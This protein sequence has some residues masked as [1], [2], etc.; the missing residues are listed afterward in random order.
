MKIFFISRTPNLIATGKYLHEIGNFVLGLNL[1]LFVILVEN[2]L[3]IY[4]DQNLM[5]S[6]FKIEYYLDHSY[7][8]LICILK[9]SI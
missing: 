8:G 3:C 5:I 2:Y 4:I 1:I 9:V 6:Y 7:R